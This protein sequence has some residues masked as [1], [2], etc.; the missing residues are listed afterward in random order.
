VLALFIAAGAVLGSAGTLVRHPSRAAHGPA[1]NGVYVAMA[2]FTPG[3]SALLSAMSHRSSC[4]QAAARLPIVRL[5]ATLPPRATDA[6]SL[7][8]MGVLL[9]GASGQRGRG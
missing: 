1:T 6:T 3:G 2:C 4:L 5:L 8:G 7:A 9:V